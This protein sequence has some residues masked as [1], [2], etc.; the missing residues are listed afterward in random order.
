MIRNP[1]RDSIFFGQM[2]KN[3]PDISTYKRSDNFF[4]MS[5]QSQRVTRTAFAQGQSPAD[6]FMWEITFS[7]YFYKNFQLDLL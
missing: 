4:F 3:I 2:I 6:F 1:A 5:L 7:S